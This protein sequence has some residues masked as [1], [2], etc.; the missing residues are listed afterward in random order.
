MQQS[1]L[2]QAPRCESWVGCI[3]WKGKQPSR[4]WVRGSLLHGVP[5]PGNL[6]HFPNFCISLKVRLQ[7]LGYST[8]HAADFSPRRGWIF[9]FS[10][11]KAGKNK[12]LNWAGHGWEMAFRVPLQ[13][14]SS[15]FHLLLARCGQSKICFELLLQ[16]K[17]ITFSLPANLTLLFSRQHPA[18]LFFRLKVV[19]TMQHYRISKLCRSA[20]KQIFTFS[21]GTATLDELWWPWARYKSLENGKDFLHGS[22][23]Q[24]SR[25]HDWVVFRFKRCSRLTIHSGEPGST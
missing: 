1:K 6:F 11:R 19:L 10:V 24:C 2:N 14:Q 22:G 4:G 13:D 20:S 25:S 16:L 15:Q 21:P 18:G 8:P 17:N 23:T 9:A 5:E 12:S 3:F 7:P